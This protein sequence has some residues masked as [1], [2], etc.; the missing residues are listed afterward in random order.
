MPWYER[1][2]CR[3]RL[4][5]MYARCSAGGAGGGEVA[6]GLR[7]TVDAEWADRVGLSVR[8]VERAV[9]DVVARDMNK[10]DPVVGRDARQ[11][12][13]A[14]RIRG[15]G[16]STPL[17]RFGD[18]DLRVCGGVDD[19]TVIAPPTR[20]RQVRTADIQLRAVGVLD[21]L[22]VAE[23]DTER[24]SSCP[25]APSTKVFLGDWDNVDQSRMCQILCGDLHVGEGI[26]QSIAADSSARLRNE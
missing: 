13:N 23:R 2:C 18:V 1:S 17:R 25:L 4:P 10:R 22:R 21:V 8:P 15:P 16:I 20:R 9:E 5:T 14:G 3:L 6:S 7:L 26:G 24:A 11:A 12:C 19:D